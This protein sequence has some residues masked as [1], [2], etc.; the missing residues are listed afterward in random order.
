MPGIGPTD[1]KLDFAGD[2]AGRGFRVLY[3]AA[4][5]VARFNPLLK[6]FYERLLA[7]GKPKKVARTAVMRKLIVLL[8]HMLKNPKFFL[9]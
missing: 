2:R 8:N 1:R 6:A 5:V 4:G 9:A 3:M 7:K